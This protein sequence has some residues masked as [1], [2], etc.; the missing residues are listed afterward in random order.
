VQQGFLCVHQ[1]G[2]IFALRLDCNATEI[3]VQ[4]EKVPSHRLVFAF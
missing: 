1:L 4:V 3:A 2:Y